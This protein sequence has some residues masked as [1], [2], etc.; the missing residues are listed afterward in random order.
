[1]PPDALDVPAC[2]ERVRRQDGEAARALVEHLYPLVI[3]IV[4]A[5][6]PRRMAEEDLAQ[7]VFL[8]MFTRL[9]QY[10]GR[11]GVPFE[12]WLSRLAVTTCLDALRAEKRRPEWRYADLADPEREWLEFFTGEAPAAA[13][14]DAMGARE[15]VEKLISLLPPDDRLVITL[16]DLQERSIADIS[17]LT[18]WSVSLVK[19]RAF[20]ARRKMRDHALKLQKE[21]KL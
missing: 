4:R 21:F 19:V 18:G 9:E 15:M 13:P 16:L 14:T 6:R 1:M 11:E 8:K 10:Q 20:R 3:K 17:A 12:H 5:H 2:L 7:E